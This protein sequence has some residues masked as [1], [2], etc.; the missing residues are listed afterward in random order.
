MMKTLKKMSECVGLFLF[1]LTAPALPCSAQDGH[2]NPDAAVVRPETT[3]QKGMFASSQDSGRAMENHQILKAFLESG[4]SESMTS[5]KKEINWVEVPLRTAAKKALDR[6]IAI[7]QAHGYKKI[8]E[9]AIQ[10]AEA[11]FDPLLTFS[12]NYAQ[13]RVFSREEKVKQWKKNTTP[14]LNDPDPVYIDLPETSPVAYLKYDKE[15]KEGYYEREVMAS[16]KIPDVP[17]ESKTY[18]VAVNQ[19]IAWGLDLDMALQAQE[20]ESYWENNPESWGPYERPWRSIF[21]ENLSIPL[22]WTKGFGPLNFRDFQVKKAGLEDNVAFWEVQI[23]KNSTLLS[24][25]FAYWDL[26]ASVRTLSALINHRKVID[27]LLRRTQA[28]Y[29]D[30]MAT[31]YDLAQVKAERARS[32]EREQLAKHGFMLFSNRLGELLDGGEDQVFLPVGYASQLNE[33]AQPLPEEGSAKNID[34]NP[35]LMKQA[36]MIQSARLLEEHRQVNA[37]PDLKFHQTLTLGQGVSLFGFDSFYDSIGQVFAGPDR[38]RQ[39]YALTYRY[40][41]LNRADESALEQARL[42]RERDLVLLD[43]IKNRIFR[44]VQDALVGLSSTRARI[45]ITRRSLDLARLAYEKA[46]EHQETRDVT[47]YE[48]VIKSADQL[49]AE[50]AFIQARIENRKT[51]ARFLAALGKLAEHQ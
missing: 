49:D 26:V 22:P 18:R 41:L 11:L 10:E 1:L 33:E 23:L 20:R 46:A 47:E 37:R 27:F 43:F 14:Y 29:D 17:D 25:E 44:E 30:R 4:V 6:N 13:T 2:H 45:G 34:K 40:P 48:V 16:E 5:P 24:V 7:L 42:N 35:E 12:Y 19:G 9:E 39:I 36:I 32:R 8:A 51:Q 15:R 38:I 50:L 3:V 28:L 31:E 21:V